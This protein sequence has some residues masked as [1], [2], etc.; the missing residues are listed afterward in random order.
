MQVD[1]SMQDVSLQTSP[2][3]DYSKPQ[4]QDISVVEI[5]PHVVVNLVEDVVRD[6]PIS[7]PT[8]T[9]STTTEIVTTTEGITQTTPRDEVTPNVEVSPSDVIS[10]PYEIHIEIN[11]TSPNIA[12]AQVVEIQK[13]YVIDETQPGLVR[14]IE[15]HEKVKKSKSKKKKKK[16]Q[17]IDA[18]QPGQST[19]VEGISHIDDDKLNEK[20]NQ[21]DPKTFATLKIT[22]TTV[23]ETSNV[24]S[25]EER[26]ESPTVTIE[27]V[28]SDENV[29]E[30]PIEG[31]G[32]Y[33]FFKEQQQNNEIIF[34]K[35][36][37]TDGNIEISQ[38]QKTALEPTV[39]VIEWQHANQIIADRIKNLQNIQNAHLSPVL[40]LTSLSESVTPESISQHVVSIDNNLSKLEDAAQTRNTVVIHETV[41]HIIEEIS[42]W[43]E[44]IEYRIYLNRQNSS[45]GPSEE[46]VQEH[47]KLLGELDQIS[48]AI[49]NL[50][51]QL[52]NTVEINEPAEQS[53]MQNCV[54][55]LKNQLTAVSNVTKESNNEHQNDLL[56]MNEFLTI[57]ETI[58]L[59]LYELQNQ[60]EATQADD[61]SPISKRLECLDN[62]DLLLVTQIDEITNALQKARGISRDFPSRPMPVDVYALYE[63]ARN[64]ENSIA[65]EKTRLMQL[66]DLSD[67]YVQT[68]HQ[69]AQIIV[70]TESLV[71]QPIR[72][73]SFDEL[74]QEMQ[75]HRKCFVNLSH[76]RM[77]LQSLGENIDS[78]TRKQHNTLHASLTD[79]AAQ[80]LEKASERAQRIS[81]AASRW[82]VLEKS[83]ADEKQWLT[84]AQQRVPDLS[85][86]STVDHERYIT[87]YRSICTDI[88]QHHARIVQLTNLATQLQDSVSA[89][90]LQEEANDCLAT[91]LKLRED[92]S[93]YLKRL[94]MFRDTWTTY[95][96]LTDRL[97][98]WMLRTERELA[99]LEIPANL[100]LEP[101]E[102]TRHFWEIRV[103]YE[104]NNKVRKQ[105]G[106]SLE[107]SI[108]ILPVRDELLQRQ[109][110]Q[111]LEE[112]W[113]NITR[114]IESIQN[115]IVTTLF[116]QNIPIDEKLDILRRELNEVE[117]LATSV[118]TV[119]K[120]EDELNVYIERLQVLNNRLSIAF[121]EL[122][123]LSLLPSHDPEQIGEIFALAHSISTPVAK[124]IENAQNLK[125]ILISLQNGI[126]KLRQTQQNN[127]AILESCESREKLSNDQVELAIVDAE[128]LT[129]ELSIQWQENMRLRQILHTLPMQLKVT[130]SPIKLERDL[131]QL[132]DKHHEQESHCSHILGLLRNRLALW[133]RFE[134]QLEIVQ[135]TNNENEFMIDLLKLNGQMDYDRLKR[136]TER[137]EVWNF[138]L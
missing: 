56:R 116:D 99:Q 127:D 118:K 125:E 57:I 94:Q 20:A 27:E 16:S 28:I 8:E 91:C 60:F 36:L 13:S 76:C 119:I 35:I 48:S 85:E 50:N 82:T 100:R 122:G 133:R 89:P 9:H 73:S 46:K 3:D 30:P 22:K 86:V 41:I 42:T 11:Q 112:R 93:I 130:M 124:E 128:H 52:E 135:Q 15:S 31:N 17:T 98:H 43:L 66:Q 47:K 81:L 110:H 78:E 74:Q 33:F 72:A 14:E 84:V 54:D 92:L 96:T 104:V 102:N 6:I 39:D 32:K 34:L 137:L 106:N 64:F 69:F 18:E 109:F 136:T 129:N 132:Q 29:N 79:K 5:V 40:H 26:P 107:R 10:E 4:V 115:T 97:E 61:N 126:K 111:Q 105:I 114:K 87:M 123:R 121:N 95:E 44:K 1:I 108:E 55:H 83:L 88:N 21:P 101:S 68:L 70:L 25:K 75:K 23:Y 24:L 67:E 131:S 134:R 58:N 49:V 63:N 38:L 65:L 62:I 120:N 80:I 59:K 138:F 77:I 2:R 7:I 71:D 103:H 51:N 117:L 53:R 12:D 90:K 45:E 37:F 19:V 113:A